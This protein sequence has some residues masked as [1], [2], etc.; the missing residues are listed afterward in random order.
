M[1]IQINKKDRRIF[2]TLLAVAEA[3]DITLRVAGGY[4]RDLILGNESNDIDIAIDKMSGLEFANKVAEYLGREADVHVVNANPEQSKH[5]ETAILY[6]NNQE[7]QFCGFRKEVYNNT[8]IPQV[9]VGTI[10]DDCLR[11]DFTINSL[12][13]NL[14]TQ[15]VEDLTGL[16]TKDLQ[17][18]IIRTPLPP[19]QTFLD[20]PL[21]ILRCV[22]FATRFNY[23]I[24]A[25]IIEAIRDPQ[26]LTAFENKVSRERI[27]I[28]MRKI[29]T[30]NNPVK[31]IRLLSDFGLLYS[32]FK[33]PEGYVDW[34]LDQKTPH[35]QLNV[36][37]HTLEA[38]SN[39][40]K[41]FTKYLPDVNADDKLVVNIA[42]LFHDL[43]KL[44]KKCWGQKVKDGKER[45]TYYNHEK[46]SLEATEYILKSL[47]GF[48]T[49]EI[50]QIKKIISGSSMVNPNYTSDNSE[51][52]LSRKGLCKFIRFCG[53]DWKNCIIVN[54][55]DASAKKKDNLE[56]M[57]FIYHS[58][59]INKIL[60]INPQ[61]IINLKPLIDG[62]KVFEIIGGKKDKRIS[63]VLNRLLEYQ[64][65]HP[66]AGVKEAI[67]FVKSFRQF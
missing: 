26:I 4:V 59:M 62:D 30:G 52:N 34:N 12:Y 33:F 55:A 56:N 65:S 22:R 60:E 18:G 38:L 8:R 3:N 2:K 67:N 44:N 53:H 31:A 11:R 46:H 15:Q 27:E 41:I 49:K 25:D 6:I 14:N 32:I 43:G 23:T 51:C 9:E 7:I 10:Q 37:D 19:K 58:S 16:G 66:K 5:L 24:Q 1:T 57:T 35:H 50:A 54:M 17:E 29:I 13:Y 40:Q 64:F 47:A 45:R 61:S 42:L 39:L 28:E 36:F 63:E 48:S 20:D 21:R